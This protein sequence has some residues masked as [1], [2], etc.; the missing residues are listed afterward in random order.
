MNICK[1]IMA[2]LILVCLTVNM[3]PAARAVDL[4]IRLSAAT[5]YSELKR[6][7]AIVNGLNAYDYTQQTWDALEEAAK[8]GNTILKGTHSQK[9]VSDAAAAIE[10][11]R[12]NL[13]KM[14][15][16][17]LDQALARVH[18][19]VEE[20]GVAYEV[21][22]QLTVA[23]EAAR[24]QTVSGNQ[25]AVNETAQQLNALLEQLEECE[26]PAREAE[27]VI[28]EVEVEVLPK[29]DYCNIPM[30]R[31]WPVLFVISAAL[32]VALIVVLTYVIM[33]KR[34]TV[35]NTPLVSYDIDDD[36]DF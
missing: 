17:A 28:Q 8:K 3:V 36:M 9:V 23:A 11:A 31:T 33:K 7:V 34:Q 32:N 2:F 20:A 25:E 30:H 18:S 1:K 4:E 35:D 27:V 12:D 14:D 15:Y 29:D 24:S 6:Q 22:Y 13:V 26:G 19:K 16:S 10:K 21:W 5:D